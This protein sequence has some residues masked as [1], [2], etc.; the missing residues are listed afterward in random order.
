[1]F[2]LTVIHFSV[3]GGGVSVLLS[4]IEEFVLPSHPQTGANAQGAIRD[5]GVH[6]RHEITEATAPPV[7]DH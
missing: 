6:G 1:M 3:V 2:V 5:H 4:A 7:A